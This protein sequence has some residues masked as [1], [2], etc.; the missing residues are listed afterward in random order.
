MKELKQVQNLRLQTNNLLEK[1]QAASLDFAPQI[2]YTKTIKPTEKVTSPRKPP[3]PIFTKKQVIPPSTHIPQPLVNPTISPERLRQKA[4]QMVNERINDNL[5]KP[6][7]FY[8]ELQDFRRAHAD[9]FFNEE[10][11]LETFAAKHKLYIPNVLEDD[12]KPA[13]DAANYCI[14]KIN[15]DTGYFRINERLYPV[16]LSSALVKMQ[17]IEHA[18]DKTRNLED[19]ERV[20]RVSIPDNYFENIKRNPVLKSRTTYDPRDSISIHTHLYK[21]SDSCWPSDYKR[22]RESSLSIKQSFKRTDSKREDKSLHT[23]PFL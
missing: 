10:P 4:V 21:G 17:E 12:I 2:L 5:T 22:K 16:E 14:L 9:L 13:Q 11:D 15:L 8:S 7:E 19:N 20:V 6:A 18:T 3:I 1:L 23:R